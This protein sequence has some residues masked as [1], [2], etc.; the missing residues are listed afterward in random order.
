MKRKVPLPTAVVLGP[1]GSDFH[2]LEWKILRSFDLKT[3]EV[4][5]WHVTRVL[6]VLNRQTMPRSANSGMTK[7][8]MCQF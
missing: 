2:S 4:N 1:L 3:D 7:S 5:M 8:Y 6:I